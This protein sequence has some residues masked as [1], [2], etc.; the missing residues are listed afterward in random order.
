MHSF[1]KLDLS[2]FPVDDRNP[3]AEMRTRQKLGHTSM[4]Q[5]PVVGCETI[6]TFY[7][8]IWIAF[9]AFRSHRGADYFGAHA[10]NILVLTFRGWAALLARPFFIALFKRATNTD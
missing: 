4:S 8:W 1:E 10:V 7:G 9:G 2:V 3:H 5:C 6:L